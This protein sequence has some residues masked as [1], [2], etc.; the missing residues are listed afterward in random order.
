MMLLPSLTLVTLLAPGDTVL[1]PL[2]PLT[3]TE[4]AVVRQ[5]LTGQARLSPG[6]RFAWL[7]LREPPKQA[8]LDQLASGRFQRE[9]EAV[10]YDWASSTPFRARVDLAG[11]RLLAWEPLPSREPPARKMIRR[12]LEEIVRQDPRWIS[13]LKQRGISD[14]GAVS[15]L[16]N[17]GESSPL[18]WRGGDRVVTAT[19]FDQERLGAGTLLRG[20]ELEVNLTRG[21]VLTLRDVRP[22]G[23][24]DSA[25]RPLSLPASRGPEPS[26]VT[27]R[28]TRTGEPVIRGSSLRWRSWQLHFG[29]HPRR[30][31]ELWDVSWNA[32]GRARR[33][34]YRASVSEAMA[35]YGDPDYTEWYPRDAGDAGLGDYQRNSALEGIDAPAGAS[36]AEAVFADEF[37]GTAIVPRAVAVYERDGG[38]LWRHASGGRRGRELVLSSHTTI[39]DYD[40]LFSWIFREDGS[41]QVE[42]GL[43]GIMLLYREAVQP[44]ATRSHGAF[45]H[46]VDAGLMAP[47]HQHFF[48]F[49]LDF[50]IDGAQPNRVLELETAGGPRNRANP[51]GLWFAMTERPLGSEAKAKRSVNPA[52]SRKWRVVNPA[53]K[54][55]LGDFSGYSLLPGEVAIPYSS[56]RAPARLAG[57]FMEAQ[58]W[59]TPYRRDEMD[60]AGEFTNFGTTGQGLPAWT[61]ADRS[62]L[63]TDVVLWYTLGVTH[64]PRPEDYP[65]MP[66]HRA[67]FSLIPSGFFAKNPA[68][69]P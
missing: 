32:G 20:I 54:N 66:A 30:G 29:V 5:V 35:A 15:I 50:D 22:A 18:P 26:P 9:A 11:G 4:L 40:F 36:F 6:M 3:A 64:I 2:D 33:V 63:D 52:A 34:L 42:V 16:P 67:S 48:S 65:V 51:L 38:L 58:L 44:A 7:A 37:G 27:P 8:V 62:V 69:A 55:A 10:L 19:G 21:T 59:V 23:A 39:D 1:H 56:P 68:L 47:N 12:R 31:L 45:G 57:G 61:G 46:R 24:V 53:I 13:A 17:L 41:I 60:A 28:P 14:P 43:T 49:R 25:P